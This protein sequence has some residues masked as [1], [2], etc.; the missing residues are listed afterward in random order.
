MKHILLLVSLSVLA[1]EPLPSPSVSVASSSVP[2]PSPIE[3][4]M[5]RSTLHLSRTITDKNGGVSHTSYETCDYSVD[6]PASA[7]LANLAA[8]IYFKDEHYPLRS[9]I[10]PALRKKIAEAKMTQEA[11]TKTSLAALESLVVQKADAKTSISLA[12]KD[13]SIST[14]IHH[15]VMGAIEDA[16]VEKDNEIEGKERSKKEIADALVQKTRV[17]RLVAW[18]HIGTSLASAAIT[19]GIFL[20]SHYGSKI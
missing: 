1:N 10:E 14:F 19:A 20:V 9:Y 17:A 13:P 3:H 8:T 11:G 5:S 2:L 4:G 15:T 12:H 7:Q 6:L 18:G 16:F